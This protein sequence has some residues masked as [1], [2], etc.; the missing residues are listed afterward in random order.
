MSDLLANPDVHQLVRFWRRHSRGARLVQEAFNH[1][2]AAVLD[3]L[4]AQ[5]RPID[6][7]RDLAQEPADFRGEVLRYVRTRYGPTSGDC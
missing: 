6:L 1:D 7:A 3:F 5:L 4:N 2:P